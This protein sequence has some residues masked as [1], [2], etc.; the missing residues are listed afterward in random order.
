MVDSGDS[1]H[2]EQ[3]QSPGGAEGQGSLCSNLS[4]SSSRAKLATD[5]HSPEIS[6]H[7][8]NLNS[9]IQHCVKHTHLSTRNK[10]ASRPT[11]HLHLANV[12]RTTLGHSVCSTQ[13][14]HSLSGEQA[15]QPLPKCL[16]VPV[17]YLASSSS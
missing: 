5:Y 3:K 6:G 7:A 10:G 11:E 1:V 16:K 17:S 8:S 4:K 9:M 12:Q 2:L 13:C 15:G 14:P